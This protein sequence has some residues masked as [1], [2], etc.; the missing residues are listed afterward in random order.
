MRKS[1]DIKSLSPSTR[2]WVLDLQMRDRSART[3]AL[4][5]EIVERTTRVSMK[6]DPTELTA[7]DIRS[8]YATRLQQGISRTTVSLE[9]RALSVFFKFAVQEGLIKTDPMANIELPKAVRPKR[10]LLSAEDMEALIKT[11]EQSASG[12]LAQRRDPALISMLVESG[13]RVG[14]LVSM[15]VDGVDPYDRT[16]LVSGKT[17][18]GV[19]SLARAPLRRSS[20]GS[21][22]ERTTRVPLAPMPSGSVTVVP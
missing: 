12:P 17:G 2:S 21:K 3:I 9:G 10:D 14:E 19:L 7:S 5:A 4:Y 16:A 8:Y 1:V 15:T 6:G 13:V 22:S 18:S 20:G 11:A